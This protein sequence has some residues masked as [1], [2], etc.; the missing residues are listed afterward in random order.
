MSSSL[1]GLNLSLDMGLC[2]VGVGT[3]CESS[4]ALNWFTVDAETTWLGRAFQSLTTL[5]ASKFRLDRE[6]A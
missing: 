1:R 2:T 5:T 4:L 3:Q 6:M